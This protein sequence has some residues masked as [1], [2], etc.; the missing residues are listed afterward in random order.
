[1]QKLCNFKQVACDAAHQLADLLIIV[2]GKRKLLIMIKDFSSHVIFHLGTHNVS[3]V[4]YE[5]IGCEL[6]QHEY[7][8]YST[9]YSD[10]LYRETGIHVRH[11][12]CDISDHQWDHQAYKR[13]KKRKEHIE[14]KRPHIWLIVACHFL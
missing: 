10:L 12:G 3:Y 1:M 13:C 7:Y 2:K 6:D 9:D 4:S 14:N 5:I 8:K 11:I